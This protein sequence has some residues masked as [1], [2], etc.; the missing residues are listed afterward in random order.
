MARS[1]AQ[2]HGVERDERQAA[3]WYAVAAERGFGPAMFALAECYNEGRGVD[4]DP[5][6]ARAW[7][8][9]LARRSRCLLRR[10][11]RQALVQIVD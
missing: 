6:Q 1:Y 3:R 7:L 2:G 9:K 10:E 8:E 11:A 4:R 5:Q